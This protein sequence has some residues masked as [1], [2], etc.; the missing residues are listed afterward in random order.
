MK[1][2]STLLGLVISL[3]LISIACSKSGT[4]TNMSDD[5]KYKLF[6]AA[7]KT[8]DAATMTQAGKAIGLVNTDGTPTDYY[9]KFIDG[10]TAWA[11]K[12]MAF[13]QEL[14]TPEKAKDYVKSHMP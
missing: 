12:N 9:K 3:T 4:A 13:V 5:D 8:G 7:T 2:K 6:Y 1:R 10:A 14:N 11:Q